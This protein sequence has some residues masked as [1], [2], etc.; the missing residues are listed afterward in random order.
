M[1]LAYRVIGIDP[2]L[3]NVGLCVLESADVS[4]YRAAAVMTI[5]S[6]ASWPMLRRLLFLREGVQEFLGHHITMREALVANAVRCRA[7]VI[8]DP[9]RQHATHTK[10]QNPSSI[11]VMSLA[12][13]AVVGVAQDYTDEVAFLDVEEW[14]PRQAMTKGK[15]SYIMPKPLLVRYLLSRIRM[16]KGADEHQI[17]A[18]GVARYWIEQERM[19]A[20]LSA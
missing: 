3:T 20:R 1:S 17:M 5:K 19:R 6:R 12:V 10:R 18:A 15:L 8:E 11:A 16:P 7:I 13:G 9:T 14:M 4:D 2:A